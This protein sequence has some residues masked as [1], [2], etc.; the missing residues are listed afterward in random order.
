MK[1]NHLKL[2]V[3]AT[4][5]MTSATAMALPFNGFDPRSMA[6]GGAGVAVGDAATAPFY[7]PSL[8]STANKG[9]R[10][11]FGLPLGMRV[12]DQDKL[13]T[14]I[15]SFQKGGY[16][17]AFNQAST[18][19][20]N[21]KTSANLTN[22]ANSMSAMSSQLNTLS[23]K[24]LTVDAGGAMVI[25][26]PGNNVGWALY[27]NAAIAA[28]GAFTY[29]DDQQIQSWATATTDV[30]NS[31][32]TV[33]GTFDGGTSTNSTAACNTAINNNPQF[34][35]AGGA[36]VFDPSTGLQS[37]MGYRGVS[38]GELGVSLSHLFETGGPAGSFA[39]GITPKLVNAQLIDYSASVNSA[40]TSTPSGSQYLAKYN[41][42]NLDVG[43]AK[44][45]NNG[46]RAGFVVKNLIPY[47]LDFKNN[48][49]PTG[50]KLKLKPQA[51]AG[52]S[53]ENKWAT[54]A[55]DVDLTRNDPAGLEK[56]SQ[57]VAMGAE[58]SAYK[59]LQLR[60][61]YRA[62]MANSKNSTASLGIGL[63]PFGVGIDAAIA[64]NK[65]QFG[66]SIQLGMHF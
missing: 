30:T 32:F 20:N 21:N 10:F 57:F 24:A 53:W 60:A 31:C 62:D 61:G 25:G 6:M 17:D 40:A 52:A 26:V 27:A 59:L 16:V 46:W 1:R 11:A 9:D 14:S 51:R 34:F 47:T 37:T 56:Q 42:I 22:L 12:G 43:L 13:L 55:L 50:A 45:Y 29:K 28:G 19:Y 35:A 15:D 7:N 5:F 2:A 63:T 64:G 18:T 4:M 33:G 39:A 44:H 54:W 66:A 41:K 48:D 3:T 65:D 49:V 8:L 36:Q 23:G 58:F 38:I